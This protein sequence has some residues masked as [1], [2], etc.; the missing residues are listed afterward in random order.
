M[1]IE[2]RHNASLGEEDYATTEIS[3]PQEALEPDDV[4]DIIDNL[5]IG[6]LRRDKLKVSN[7]L[8]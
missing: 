4:A 7:E 5:H 3:Y 6:T 8:V 1:S 2:R